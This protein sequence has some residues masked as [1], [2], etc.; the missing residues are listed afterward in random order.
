MK[1]LINLTKTLISF[2]FLFSLIA[3]GG[4]GSSSSD[5]DDNPGGGS[6]TPSFSVATESTSEIGSYKVTVTGKITSNTDATFSNAGILI[7]EKPQPTIEQSTFN[8]KPSKFKTQSS[9]N[10]NING[11]TNAS[12][13]KTYTVTF[14]GLRPNTSYH[15]R[16]YYSNGT[17]IIYGQDLA[18]NT[19]NANI[20]YVDLGL[21]SKTMWAKCNVAAETPQETGSYFQIGETIPLAYYRSNSFKKP[22]RDV[23]DGKDPI[24]DLNETLA[25]M[26]PA[27]VYCGK[28]WRTPTIDQIKELIKECNWIW[29]E[30]YQNSEVK[31][32]TVRSSK[33]NNEI[34]IPVT[35]Y[36]INNKKVSEANSGFYNSRLTTT[37]I[38]NNRNVLFF[39]NTQKTSDKS[40]LGTYACPIRPVKRVK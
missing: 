19:K 32:Y 21:T 3:C 16:A 36:Y 23:D 33:N 12:S 7:S 15:C 20:E 39:D 25:K 5:D 14:T 11:R 30:N 37:T 26:D 10:T 28:D 31:G 35:G 22:T 24:G 29:T 2:S 18:F 27:Y 9:V 38:P 17:K 6:D 34:F 1:K 40:I 4:G 8:G 13:T